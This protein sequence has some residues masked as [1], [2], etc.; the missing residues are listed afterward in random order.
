M[1][2]ATNS[3]NGGSDHARSMFEIGGI[4][5]H[6][7]SQFPVIENSTTAGKIWNAVWGTSREDF[8]RSLA[9]EAVKRPRIFTYKR[10]ADNKKS[11]IARLEARKYAITE[12]TLN[13][14]DILP[15][16]LQYLDLL[17]L[18]GA[19]AYANSMDIVFNVHVTISWRLLGRESA[20]KAESALSTLFIR[21]YDQWCR[22][23]GITCYWIYTNE[24]SEKVGL[25]T[26]FM[27]SIPRHMLSDF[28]EYMS[29]RMKKIN[30]LEKLN[31]NAC[32]IEVPRYR[33]PRRLCGQWRQFQYLC[34][35]LDPYAKL[36]HEHGDAVVA[37]DL[38]QWAYESPGDVSCKKRCGLSR[39]LN[40]VACKKA[41]FESA[42][43]KGQLYV[44]VLYP[45]F[46]PRT[47]AEIDADL[48]LL[49][50]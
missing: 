11:K 1:T 22:D 33:D 39:N 36:R 6:H 29:R 23:K 16:N 18:Y 12:V 10:T 4:N 7:S 37:A 41:G 14:P 48:R 43:D 50:I 35:G 47:E 27:T 5:Y 30:L 42:M 19:V 44:D 20:S 2:S 24:G 32:K 31:E 15:R 45:M 28:R 9:A 8:E 26:H 34:K 38:L 49:S 3:S 13:D 40:E 17:N 21:Q 25:H 46:R